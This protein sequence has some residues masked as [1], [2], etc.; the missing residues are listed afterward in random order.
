[1]LIG[2]QVTPGGPQCSYE[3]SCL[4]DVFVVTEQAH[5]APTGAASERIVHTLSR[6]KIKSEINYFNLLLCLL[7]FHFLVFNF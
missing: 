3:S 6:L 1:M 7:K 2:S 4:G 5:S